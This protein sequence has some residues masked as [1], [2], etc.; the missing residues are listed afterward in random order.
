[1]NRKPWFSSYAEMAMLAIV[2][3][4]LGGTALSWAYTRFGG[5]LTQTPTT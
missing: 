5:L 4:A 2:V 1:M 3:L